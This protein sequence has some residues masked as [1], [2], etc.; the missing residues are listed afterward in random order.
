MTMERMRMTRQEY[1]DARAEIQRMEL[2]IQAKYKALDREYAKSVPFPANTFVEVRLKD[3]KTGK[4]YTKHG[5]IKSWFID[6]ERGLLL[7]E[8]LKVD[9]KGRVTDKNQYYYWYDSIL[10]I[11]EWR[12][13]DRIKDTL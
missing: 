4:T 1:I 11:S 5:F 8:L 12:E 13:E 6:H 2:V 10:S 9:L 7:P 3:C